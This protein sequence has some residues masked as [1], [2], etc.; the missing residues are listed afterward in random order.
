MTA[1][2]LLIL[3]TI[4]MILA[5]LPLFVSFGLGGYI[6]MLVLETD[7]GFA[8]PAIFTNLNSF[9]LMAIPFFNKTLDRCSMT[10]CSTTVNDHQSSIDS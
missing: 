4:L 6:M 5:G 9:V 2:M 1:L 8:V 10:S 3:L 7:P